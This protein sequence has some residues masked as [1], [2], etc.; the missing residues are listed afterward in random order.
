MTEQLLRKYNLTVPET[1]GGK[2]LDKFL[3]LTLAEFSRTRLKSLILEGQVILGGVKLT[4]PAY[5]V[6]FGDE[7]ALEVPMPRTPSLLGQPI[8]LNIIFEDRDIIVLEKPPGLVVHPAPG[9]PDRTLVNALIAHC[10][11][12]LSGIGGETRPGIVHRLDKDT[13]GLML[14]AKNDYSH[15]H[16]AEQFA[17]HTIDRAYYA[18]VWGTVRPKRGKV[19]GN[20]GRNP[21]NRKKMAVVK[22]GGKLALTSYDRRKCVGDWASLVE[23]RLDTGRTHQIR[24]HMAS[25]GHPVVRD[26]LY[27]GGM[28]MAIRSKAPEFCEKVASLGRHALHAYLLGFTHPRTGKRLRFEIALAEEIKAL[29]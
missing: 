12:S 23:C 4:D 26:P 15:R 7:I 27:G 1:E 13:S 6:N 29:L 19:S 3:S 14:A 16:L 20:I 28:K 5:R 17:N 2:R 22:K 25:I 8:A 9:N 21:K 11:E 10:G 24:V 18:L